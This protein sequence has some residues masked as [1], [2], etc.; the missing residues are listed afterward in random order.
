MI[1][2]EEFLRTMIKANKIWF[3]FINLILFTVN[4]VLRLFYYF[5]KICRKSNKSNNTEFY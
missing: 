3:F 1:K 5:I 2:Q 4:I